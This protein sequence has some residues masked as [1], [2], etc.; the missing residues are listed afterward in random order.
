MSAKQKQGEPTG[1]AR[2]A[3]KRSGERPERVDEA[4]ALAARHARNALAEAVL[5][6]HALLDAASLAATGRPAGAPSSGEPASEVTG[7][8]ARLVQGLDELAER[9]RA[10]DP[11]ATRPLVDALLASL[12]AEITRWES[13]ARSDPDARAVLRAFLGLRELLWELGLRPEPEATAE[14]APAPRSKPRPGAG[15]ASTSRTKPQST[16]KTR[17]APKPAQ[18]QAARPRSRRRVQRVDI[19][20]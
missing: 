10:D 3:K 13:E 20:S 18:K 4:L 8:L 19:E 1:A 16:A 6:G 9:L 12:D 15:T 2:R 11:D 17:A 5:A 14:P 7:M